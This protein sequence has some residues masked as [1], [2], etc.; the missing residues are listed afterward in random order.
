MSKVIT[1]SAPG[2]LMLF[3]EHAVVYGRPCIVTAVNQRMEATVELTHKPTFEL[4]APD[5]QVISYVKPINQVGIGDMPKGAK[6]IEVAIKNFSENYPIK[7]GVKVSTTS[8]FSSEYGLG[9]SSA[10]TVCIIKALSELTKLNLDNKG[11]FDLAYKSVLDIQGKGSGFD[12]AAAIFG[13]TLYYV[14]PGKVIEPLILNIDSLPLI[15]GY[16]GIK[17]DTVTLINQVSQLAQN[18]PQLIENIYNEIGG[19]VEK[20]KKAILSKDWQ[21]L[22]ELLNFDQGYLEVLGVSIAKLSAMI[23]GARGAGAYGAKLSGAGG[24]D[25]MIAIAPGDKTQAV[26]NAITKAGGKVIDVETN[27]EGVRV[28]L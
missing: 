7:G 18:H 16:T 24:G 19:L 14:T 8:E 23:H 22:G 1:V 3:G 27:V 4:E 11:I 17:A 15:V 12:V 5:V 9:S 13:G 28:E 25:C 26:K 2:K 6:F 10:S 20:A 21:A